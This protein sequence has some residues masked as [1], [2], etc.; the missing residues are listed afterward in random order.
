MNG[1]TE[2]TVEIFWARKKIQ[3]LVR[4]SLEG[5]KDMTLEEV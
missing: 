1:L 5:D 3:Y 4:L 2:N